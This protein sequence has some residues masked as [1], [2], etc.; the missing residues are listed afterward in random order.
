MARITALNIPV[1]LKEKYERI[2]ATLERWF[3]PRVSR[4]PRHLSRRRKAL[5]RQATYMFYVSDLW[6]QKTAGDKQAWK[7]AGVKM[8]LNGWQLYLQDKV[9]RVEN[10]IP[11]DAVPSIYHQYF[12]GHCKVESPASAILITQKHPYTFWILEKV[13]GRKAMYRYTKITD[14]LT[15]PFKIALSRK[16]N[17]TSVGGLPYCYLIAKIT[18]FYDGRLYYTEYPIDIPLVADWGYQEKTIE[19]P[20]GYVGTYEL[21]IRLNDVTG[22]IYFDNIIS[23]HDGTNFARDPYCN[24]I[25]R[26]FLDEW[27]RVA[28]NWE[29]TNVPA[30]ALYESIYPP[31]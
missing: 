7:D 9:Y 25:T 22:E 15:F 26:E 23:E 24:E 17:L 21:Q 6:R 31:D 8:G 2:M 30:G 18:H 19:H 13:S 14:R 27:F 1:D 5:L 12:V 20:G 3:F 10:N 11:G 29:P 16:T 4:K 28:H